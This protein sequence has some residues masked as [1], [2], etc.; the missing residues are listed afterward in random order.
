M[1]EYGVDIE[2]LEEFWIDWLDIKRIWK[3]WLDMGWVLEGV[4]SDGET[5]REID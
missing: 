1:K 3:D 4:G 2:R 5:L